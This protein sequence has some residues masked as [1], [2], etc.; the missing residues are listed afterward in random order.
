MS[1]MSMNNLEDPAKKENKKGMYYFGRGGLSSTDIKS[2]PFNKN[3]TLT[4][5]KPS[6]NLDIPSDND[7]KSEGHQKSTTTGN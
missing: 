7:Y 6:K 1:S 3:E 2:P 4:L 5:F